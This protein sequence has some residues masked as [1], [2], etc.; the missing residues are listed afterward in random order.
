MQWW[1]HF[2]DGL[3]NRIYRKRPKIL[4][5]HIW[6]FS[7]CDKQDKQ[8]RPLWNELGYVNRHNEVAPTHVTTYDVGAHLNLEHLC[9]FWKENFFPQHCTRFQGKKYSHDIYD[10][11]WKELFYEIPLLGCGRVVSTL[12]GHVT[13]WSRSFMLYHSFD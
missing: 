9:M 8:M 12:K 3:W 1:D 4:K 5:V 2:L 13:N 10:V 11:L 7:F 6:F